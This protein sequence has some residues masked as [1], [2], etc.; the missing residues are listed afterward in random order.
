MDLG[1]LP[2]PRQAHPP[3]FD[4]PSRTTL[5][6]WI[7]RAMTEGWVERFGKGR[8]TSPYR[9]ALPGKTF[10][11]MGLPPFTDFHEEER[12]RYG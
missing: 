7:E 11:P 12:E 1:E 4:A 5:R 10:D 3:D 2:R 6:D 9:Y 8:R